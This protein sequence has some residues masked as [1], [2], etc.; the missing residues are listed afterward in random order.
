MTQA[1]N[2]P[3][4]LQNA[5]QNDK[6]VEIHRKRDKKDNRNRATEHHL[7]TIQVIMMET[8]KDHHV[9]MKITHSDQENEKSAYFKWDYGYVKAKLCKMQ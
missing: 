7:M 4:R 6:Q 5:A 3:K 1:H 8:T 2:I 9:V